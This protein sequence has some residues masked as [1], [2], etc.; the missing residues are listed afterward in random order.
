MNNYELYHHGV[1]GMKW[2][3]RRTAAQLGHSPAA[4]KASAAGKKFGKF[5]GKQATKAKKAAVTKVKRDYK[6]YREKKYYQKLHKKKLSQMTDKEIKDLTKRVQQETILKD[7]KYEM[8][9]RNARKFYN[10][11]A[12]QPV[13]SFATTFG[14]QLAKK[15]VE[16]MGKETKAVS[17]TESAASAAKTVMDAI[18]QNRQNRQS[19]K[20]SVD[21]SVEVVNEP[22]KKS[23]LK[24]PSY[25]E[26]SLASQKQAEGRMR[27]ESWTNDFNSTKNTS[28]SDRYFDTLSRETTGRSTTRRPT[29]NFG[30]GNRVTPSTNSNKA[31]DDYFESEVRKEERRRRR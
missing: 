5:V 7:A 16:D 25:L 8:R 13:N 30:E 6:E 15:I 21:V 22:P 3:V 14:T 19:K 9:T 23:T 4:K 28:T 1:K 18:S 29:A 10:E 24:Q 12:K 31:F 11:V 26:R 20:N 27:A 2:G 17:S